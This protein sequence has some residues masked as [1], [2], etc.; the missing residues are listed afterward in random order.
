MPSRKPPGTA[1][2]LID[3]I[4]TFDFPGAAPLIRAALDA[5]PRIERLARR[6]RAQR[7]PVVYV[8]DNFGRWS[9]DFQATVRECTRA[10]RP[11]H[12][13][14][15][16]LR[17][18]QGDYF[19]LKPQHSGFYGTPLDLLLGH[20]GVHTLV[21]AGF[22]TDICVVFTANDAHMRGYHLVVPR[23]VCAANT[24]ALSQSALAHVRAALGGQTPLSTAI[25]FRAHA[26]RRRKP[27]GQTF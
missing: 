19:V 23:D 25:D 7:A 10:D 8:N 3:V 18:I 6:A 2:L 1:L 24:K 22:A 17:P 27:R 11:G 26:G 21:L 15:E 14:C 4:N 5:A 9:S 16:R 12:L 13:A 20:L